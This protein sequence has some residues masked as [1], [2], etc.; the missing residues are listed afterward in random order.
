MKNFYQAVQRIE[1]SIENA[2]YIHQGFEL[3]PEFMQL[4]KDAYHCMVSRVDYTQA[5][6]AAKEINEWVEKQTKNKIKD[7]VRPG[8]ECN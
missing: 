2:L 7:I 5:V 4:S 1:L 3:L 8:K 6:Q